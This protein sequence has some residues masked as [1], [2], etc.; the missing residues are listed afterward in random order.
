MTKLIQYFTDGV[1]AAVVIATVSAIGL[2]LLYF[3]V[4]L[5]TFAFYRAK[6]QA[7]QKQTHEETKK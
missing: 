1:Q 7:Q 2:S 3:A 4:K 5:A 6:A